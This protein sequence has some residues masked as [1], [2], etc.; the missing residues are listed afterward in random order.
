MKLV[1][2]ICRGRRQR[3]AHRVL[4]LSTPPVNDAGVSNLKSQ[5]L[6]KSRAIMSV[7]TSS[8][9]VMPPHSSPLDDNQLSAHILNLLQI[10]SWMRWRRSDLARNGALAC[11]DLLSSSQLQPSS[12]LSAHSVSS[13]TPASCILA[14]AGTV[15]YLLRRSHPGTGHGIQ[16]RPHFM[17]RRAHGNRRF[18]ARLGAG[19]SSS[20]GRQLGCSLVSLR[21]S[22]LERLHKLSG[23]RVT[24]GVPSDPFTP[25]PWYRQWDGWRC[26]GGSGCCVDRSVVTAYG[27][28]KEKRKRDRVANLD[29]LRPICLT[30]F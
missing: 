6:P 3:L 23:Q 30:N 12:S 22:Q 19:P 21:T 26:V 15:T 8:R 16:P 17:P 2:T 9:K 14:S 25:A 29:S 11:W 20:S 7:L 28:G 27:R 24:K 1:S 18:G 13:R 4:P 10:G 5:I